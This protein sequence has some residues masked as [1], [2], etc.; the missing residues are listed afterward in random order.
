M[1]FC[2]TYNFSPD[3]LTVC[4]FGATCWRE[5]CVCLNYK[6]NCAFK[7]GCVFDYK[8]TSTIRITQLPK[9]RAS[10]YRMI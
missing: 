1:Q 7:E 10:E 8:C 5:N 9:S 2:T 6:L 4:K 3:T